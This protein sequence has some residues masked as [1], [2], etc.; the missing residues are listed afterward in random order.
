MKTAWVNRNAEHL[1]DDRI[2][3]DFVG[4][5]LGGLAAFAG[6]PYDV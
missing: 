2:Q 6:K 3:P 5:D 4:P 1:P